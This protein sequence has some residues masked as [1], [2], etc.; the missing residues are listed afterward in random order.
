MYRLWGRNERDGNVR[1]ERAYCRIQREWGM[2]SS[3]WDE[4]G[5]GQAPLSWQAE[6]MC[7]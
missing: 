4:P 3:A 7:V 2:E 1:V 5:K 6:G